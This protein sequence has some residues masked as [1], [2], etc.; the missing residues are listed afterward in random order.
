MK[1]KGVL[2]DLYGTLIVY[3]DMEKAWN[4]WYDVIYET[5]QTKRSYLVA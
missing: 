5:F 2:F 4:A 3:G 1:T